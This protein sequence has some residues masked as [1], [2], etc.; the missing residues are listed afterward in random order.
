MKRSADQPGSD[1]GQLLTQHGDK[2]KRMV[3]CRLDRRLQGRVDPSDVVQEAY[4]EAARRY[5]EYQRDPRMPFFLW[6]RFLTV[7]QLLVVH[8]RHLGAK[9][10]TVKREASL[11]LARTPD[12]N[13][14][15]LADG[16]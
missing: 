9:M 4:I 15:V 8:R 1:V 16:L 7:Q 3:R 12:P 6:L 10:R 14:A 11:D 2:L 13:L 5:P